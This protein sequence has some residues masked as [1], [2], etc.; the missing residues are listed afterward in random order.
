MAM[1]TLIAPAPLPLSPDWGPADVDA[2]GAEE[3]VVE[4][5]ENESLLEE[6]LEESLEDSL[7]L[8]GA[9]ALSLEALVMAK[10]CVRLKMSVS[11]EES[12]EESP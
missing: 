3:S 4:G 11:E 9:K 10:V 7:V 5:S 8:S 6:S 1:G 2:A 12:S